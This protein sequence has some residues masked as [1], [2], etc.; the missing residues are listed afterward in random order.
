MTFGKWWDLLARYRYGI[1]IDIANKIIS[2][3]NR[4]INT[5]D[6]YKDF[7]IHLRSDVKDWS[8]FNVYGMD[9]GNDNSIGI[10]ADTIMDFSPRQIA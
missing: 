9:P 5:D 7:W 1:T 4:T 3:I 2:Y 8:G 10:L 6:P